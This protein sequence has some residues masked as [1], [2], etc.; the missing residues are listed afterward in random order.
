MKPRPSLSVSFAAALQA[1]AEHRGF[2]AYVPYLLAASVV[3]GSSLA[4]YTPADFWATDHWDVSTAVYAGLLAFNGLLMAL[5]WF[6]FSKIY[7]ILVGDRLGAMLTK[8][9][10]LGVHLA[11]IELSHIVL[12]VASL[13][14][15][16]GLISVLLPLP[17][18]ADR[19]LFGATITSTIYALVRAVSS[20]N[21]VNQLVWEQANLP[22]TSA[23]V[24]AIGPKP[25]QRLSPTGQ[26]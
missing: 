1:D 26:R 18:L 11:F 6:A 10:L 21:V 8:H 20:V 13:S 14:T 12:V 16:V 19:I 15:A 9:D 25:D 5:G 3:A 7:E 2:L 23:G 17:I 22:R 4:Y 24:T